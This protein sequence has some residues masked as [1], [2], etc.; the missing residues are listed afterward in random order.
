MIVKLQSAI[1]ID[2]P[3]KAVLHDSLV[4]VDFK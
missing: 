1:K 4:Q 3:A 2:N